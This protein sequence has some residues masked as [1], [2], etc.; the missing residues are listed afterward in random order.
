MNFDFTQAL[1]LLPGILIG[2]AFHEFAHA[3]TAVWLGD[4]TPKLQRRNSLNPLV[5]ID[6]IGF[7][8]ILLAGFGWA[9][10]VQ[11]NP[12]NFK[13]PKR[14]DILVSVAGPAMNILVALVLLT[15]MRILISIPIANTAG[16][17]YA[18]LL[19]ILD[20]AVWINIVLCVFNLL[21]I[22]PLDGSHILF[23]LTGLKNTEVYFKLYQWSTL[24]LLVLILTRLLGKIIGPPIYFIYSFLVNLFF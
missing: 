21:P 19:T 9:K 12:N 10:P 11:I 16:S 13:N 20:Y 22:P 3:Q 15:L 17:T 18:I 1:Y 7:I 8:M 6:I 23:G 4:D 24:I 5:H 2:F 14:D